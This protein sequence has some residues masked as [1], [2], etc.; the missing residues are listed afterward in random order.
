[1]NPRVINL[2]KLNDPAIWDYV[3][4]PDFDVSFYLQGR[5]LFIYFIH[6][7]IYKPCEYKD[8]V[9]YFVKYYYT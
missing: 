8:F 4:K 2:I 3:K 1:M 7:S 6:M 5:S 9:D